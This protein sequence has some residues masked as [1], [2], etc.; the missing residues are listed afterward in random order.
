MAHMNT[1]PAN[2][3][4]EAA[5]PD[6]LDRLLDLVREQ[7]IEPTAQGQGL[8]YRLPPDVARRVNQAFRTFMSQRDPS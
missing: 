1:S 5:Q 6:A 7:N 3:L 8:V 4:S 2:T